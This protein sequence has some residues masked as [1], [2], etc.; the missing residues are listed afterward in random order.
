MIGPRLARDRQIDA[1]NNLAMVAI[2]AGLLWLGWN[3]FNGGDPYNA[4]ADASSAVL[5]TTAVATFV[6][7]TAEEASAPALYGSPPLK[8]FQPSHRSPAPM[9]TIARLLGRVDLT[10]TC[11][12]GADHPCGDEARDAGR[13]MNDV[14]HPRS[15]LRPAV[16]TSRRPRSGRR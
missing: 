3:G 1:P 14:A 10:V 2:G 7:R 11:E 9:A 6:F 13:E 12:P 8:P 4:G 15:P 16:R 5:N